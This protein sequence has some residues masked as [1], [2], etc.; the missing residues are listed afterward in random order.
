MFDFIPLS[1]ADTSR[2]VQASPLA[3]SLSAAQRQR[4]VRLVL[5]FAATE[6]EAR[7]ILGRAAGLMARGEREWDRA[8][9]HA[10]LQ[11]QLAPVSNRMPLQQA[12]Y[13]AGLSGIGRWLSKDYGARQFIY[14]ELM[15]DVEPVLAYHRHRLRRNRGGGEDEL[16]GLN[17]GA[18]GLLSGRLGYRALAAWLSA[19]VLDGGVRAPAAGGLKGAALLERDPYAQTPA[20][21]RDANLAALEVLRR[22]QRGREASRANAWPPVSA[23]DLERLRLF[24]GWGGFQKLEEVFKGE[25]RAV[26]SDKQR[27]YLEIKDARTAESLAWLRTHKTRMPRTA[28][29]QFGDTADAF[30]G[31]IDQYFT[32]LDVAEA[33]IAWAL[34]G[35]QALN[36]GRQPTRVLEPSAGIGRFLRAWQLAGHPP[37]QWDVVEYEP[38][39]AD[40]LEL[41]Y[42]EP[43]D[44]RIGPV[45][46]HR[47]AFESFAATAA[48]VYDIVVANPPYAARGGT[49]ALDPQGQQWE[50]AQD[51]F[52]A[53]TLSLLKPG[54]VMVHLV[55]GG[56][57]EGTGGPGRKIRKALLKEAHFLGAVLVPASI[58][59][60]EGA[61]LGL[62]I[63]L[64]AKRPN[65]LKGVLA[66]D[67]PIAAGRYFEDP[68]FARGV[69][70]QRQ[71]GG[72]RGE[73][74]VGTFSRE[75]MLHQP[76]RKPP[77]SFG[78]APKAEEAS[79]PARGRRTAQGAAGGRLGYSTADPVALGLPLSRRV[80]S[81]QA[82]LRDVPAI[83]GAV[84]AELAEDVRA[85]VKRFGSP[86]ALAGVPDL[87]AL[88]SVVT[89][90]GKLA[91][92]LTQ[93]VS[94]K[95]IGYKGVKNAE[96]VALHLCRMDGYTTA[97]RVAEVMDDASVD[98]AA[99]ARSTKL[100]PRYDKVGQHSV[101]VFEREEEYFTGPV[102]PKLRYLERAL[103]GGGAGFQVTPGLR[104]RLMNARDR[105]LSLVDP[106]PI[107][108][109]DIGL[110]SMFVHNR[111]KAEDGSINFDCP[112]IRDWIFAE[113]QLP[114]TRVWMEDG[115]L[116]AEGPAEDST[117]VQSILGYVNR[118]DR[119]YGAD[120]SFSY[121]QDRQKALEDRIAEDRQLDE[122]FAA[123][124]RA[125]RSA[126]AIAARYNEEFR[127][128][129]PRVYDDTPI[130]LG[131]LSPEWGRRIRRHAWPAVRRAVERFGG[132]MSLDV[133]IGKTLSSLLSYAL[134]RQQGKA[135]RALFAV[136]NTVAPNWL[137][138]IA[139]WL[140]DYRPVI[141]GVTLKPRKDGTLTSVTDSEEVIRQKLRDFADG[142]YDLAVVTHS[143]FE[144]FGVS[145]GN[146]QLLAKG[147][148][149]AAKASQEDRKAAE[150]ELRKIAE[151]EARLAAMDAGDPKY[152]ATKDHLDQLKV[153]PWVERL[154]VLLGKRKAAL[155][156][157]EARV[158]DLSE[159]R[160]AAKA[161]RRLVGPI[162]A[163]LK[164]AKAAAKRAEKLLK[165]TEKDLEVF[166][167]RGAPSDRA[168]ASEEEKLKKWVNNR[169]GGHYN[170]VTGID[171]ESLGVDFLVVDEAHEFKN[172]FGAQTR[173][174]KSARYMGSMDAN[175]VVGKCWNLFWKA[176]Y[177]RRRHG[178]RGGVL[179][180]TATPLKNSP[181][182]AYNLL[183]YV[184]DAAFR[185]RGILDNE[186]FIDRYCD[187]EP[188]PIMT[189]RGGFRQDM[190]VRR[191]S[192][193]D[194]L[195]GLFD[196]FVDVKVAARPADYRRMASEGR[197]M[198][199][200]VELPLPEI[201]KDVYHVPMQG[202]QLAIYDKFRQEAI[203][204][205]ETAAAQ[206]CQREEENLD[207]S[208]QE[209]LKL[210]TRRSMNRQQRIWVLSALE[211]QHPKVWEIVGPSYKPDWAELMRKDASDQ[212]T[213]RRVKEW[214]E[215]A[216]EQI[217]AGDFRGALVVP[218]LEDKKKKPA[219]TAG[220]AAGEDGEK[221]KEDDIFT[222]MDKLSKTALDPGLLDKP[223]RV[224]PPKF[225]AVAA[226]VKRES[227]CAH[228]VFCDYSEAYPRLIEALVKEGGVPRARIK[229]I[230]G[231]VPPGQRQAIAE[232]F[233]GAWDKQAG[234]WV[235]PPK[236]DIIIGGKAIEQGINLQERTCAIHHLTLPWEPA[237]LQQRNGRGDRQGNRED[238]LKVR[239]Y[240]AERSFDGYKLAMIYG[241]ASW[242]QTLLDSKDSTANNPGAEMNSPCALIKQLAADATRAEE[243]CKCLE[244]AASIKVAAQK[245]QV[246]L[247]LFGQL[248]EAARAA[249]RGG[250]DEVQQ[251]ERARDL[252]ARLAKLDDEVFPNK[253]MLRHEVPV[254]WDS[255]RDLFWVQ[256]ASI[257]LF[258]SPHRVE[259]IN[260]AGKNLTVRPLGQWRSMKL[261]FGDA[262]NYNPGGDCEWTDAQDSELLGSSGLRPWDLKGLDEALVLERMDALEKAL[263]S[264]M[265]SGAKVPVVTAGG[266][267][268][269]REPI[270]VQGESRY[271]YS[272]KLLNP[273]ERLLLPYSREDAERWLAEV[274]DAKEKHYDRELGDFFKSYFGRVLPPKQEKRLPPKKV[275]GSHRY[276]Y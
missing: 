172:L 52:M 99:L 81:L 218:Q 101:L 238:T 112:L 244:N 19:L 106:K 228:I 207:P 96:D 86:H 21:R 240:V 29:T 22:A 121:R 98:A 2:L 253:A 196:A 274:F 40:M 10:A 58:F 165:E 103:G 116:Q 90:S 155:K 224:T 114:L 109:I 71:A 248:Q 195:R 130:P 223:M 18:L 181:L 138:E 198:S 157:A 236:Y 125:S 185:D 55:P 193:L 36:S 273:G 210:P 257:C 144:R 73:R 183:S 61:N 153:T 152:S 163:K 252:R 220:G 270:R 136:P 175:K 78:A 265:Y 205:A 213:N 171:Y 20:T 49:L 85:Y 94:T 65:P 188:E 229:V 201:E 60:G 63:S 89:P 189:V 272:Y 83:A 222:I 199:R 84:Q 133:G 26:L 150:R 179:L 74:L 215:R 160:K 11:L 45:Q 259:N 14:R 97:A 25:S 203:R 127:G 6:Q 168:Q 208:K 149:A 57:I 27:R 69:M 226:N 80:V 251:A 170:A 268:V 212:Y 143:T 132:I 110:R 68:T 255:K 9:Q 38:D 191:F 135:R 70:G 271:T 267:I 249:R 34:K 32:R 87:D 256:G 1:S 50:R 146:A 30:R 180:L 202:V 167:E 66:A 122:A 137:R 115:V 173:Q 214:Y 162:D 95:D 119:L 54:G 48:P 204:A 235:T 140:P 46:V 39:M 187:P 33:M 72:F 266:D 12:A 260:L 113:Y 56:T 261:T 178:G 142:I 158:A 31:L 139:Q 4:A 269:M 225:A 169:I 134:L 147:Y 43:E 44:L 107:E 177:T 105:L 151:V 264:G 145:R 216:D 250:V 164:P 102:Y 53:R 190:A 3:R 237:T 200:V 62:S 206:L 35:Y 192:N 51:Y 197:D 13:N 148:F 219:K 186:Q 41:L 239:Y 120:G 246:A 118:T 23:A 194:E 93:A 123:F 108:Q 230:T 128:Y 79:Q 24:S 263:A 47:G 75:V 59:S 124:V 233:N 16:A 275:Y 28:G 76:L 64:W 111:S 174:G 245:R 88:R 92:V 126:D 234:R 159:E 129:I 77:V 5:R 184:T 242:M 262:G 82:T 104:T 254:W 211:L 176:A 67:K 8:L 221:K 15:D 217:E 156:A 161:A 258:N 154:E 100:W 7:G 42:E 232:A 209:E 141:V 17:P 37:A 227:G 247:K 243:F 117:L 276:G 166:S 231:K 241:K 131:R 182:E 91:G